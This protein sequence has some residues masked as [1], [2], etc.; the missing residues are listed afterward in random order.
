MGLNESALGIGQLRMVFHGFAPTDALDEKVRFTDDQISVVSKAFLGLTVSCARCHDHKFD[1]ISQ[2]DY[3]SWYGIF[4]SCPPAAI[5]VDAPDPEDSQR[6]ASLV[7]RK[8][9]LKAALAQAW[10][11]D[12]GA[13]VRKLSQ[14]N[15]EWKKTIEAAK[16]PDSLLHP[17][18]LLQHEGAKTNSPDDTLTAWWKKAAA[19]TTNRAYPKKWNLT[20][21]ADF[22]AWRHDGPGVGG[23]SPAGSFAVASEGESILTG[24]YPAGV[25]SHLLSSKDRGVVLSPTFQL[26]EKYDLWMR[27]AGEGGAM[28]RYVVQNY[29]R[30]G[31]IYQVSRPGGG[32]WRWVKLGLDYWQGDQIHVEV[33]TAADQPVLADLGATRSW[34]GLSSV[35]ITRAGDPSPAEFWPFAEPVLIA[36]EQREPTNAAELAEGYA[37]AIRSAVA[38]WLQGSLTDSQALFLGQ[39]VKL[40]L[41]PNQSGE[42]AD[43][44]PL[45]T[46]CRQVEAA[47]PVPTRAQGVI[48]TD[49]GD[50]PIF[51]RGNHKQ[52]GASVARHFLEAIDATPYP[53][54]GSGRRELAENLVR[55]DN[56]L[57]SRVIV[58]RVW[59]HLFGRGLVATP[60]NFG[61]MGLEPSHP[62]LLDYLAGRFVDDG[63]SLKSLIRFLVLSDAWQLSSE[64]PARA[65]E[66][67]PNNVL[68]SHFSVRRLE[69]E[70]IRDGMLAVSGDLKTDPMFGPPVKGG[71][72]RRSVYLRVKRNDLDPFLAAFDTPVPASTTGKREVTNVPGQSLT[73]LNDPFVIKLA[74]DWAHQV[75]QDTPAGKS[76]DRIQAMFVRALGRPPT[77][78]EAR[79]SEKFL[80]WT[81]AEHARTRTEQAR[82]EGV[83]KEDSAQLA[84][85][86]IAARPGPQA[87]S[88]LR[89]EAE[90]QMEL[91]QAE[92]ALKL[93]K[94]APGLSSEWADLAHALFNMKEFIFVR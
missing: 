25:Y 37:A 86:K 61:R 4:S 88:G 69:A 22:A 1:P 23:I 33:T 30:D 83:I 68:L 40:G 56:P 36:C 16:E 48:E 85:L 92:E 14:P 3:Y 71:E 13:A 5:A 12:A 74:E 63:W 94:Q 60:D 82:L 43:L 24:I 76:E 79:R 47:I 78:A 65:L 7:E 57:T 28:A 64:A 93:L 84:A 2:K 35:V 55:P 67:D 49:A 90:L 75:E 50:Q 17:F 58:N 26:D 44:K 31:T 8:N 42:L 11:R 32:Q 80:T 51:V 72:P 59:H 53:G 21:A 91:R 87:G 81:A 18:F 62:E 34:F 54:T 20:N 70:A 77:T 38:A 15:D 9:E 27:I 41:L 66:K 73:L 19:G 46:A 29:P 39:S 6:R 10:L 89:D 45:V 52:P